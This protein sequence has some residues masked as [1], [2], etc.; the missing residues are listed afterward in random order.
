M[1]NLILF[2]FLFPISVFATN[3]NDDANCMGSWPMEQAAGTS[4]TDLS[5]E[6]ETLTELD[7]N[8]DREA[9]TGSP[10]GTYSRGDF[11]D[12]NH[13]FYHADGGST[14]ISGADQKISFLTWLKSED[15]TETDAIIAKYN[16]ASGQRAYMLSTSTNACSCAISHDGSDVSTSVGATDQVTTNWEHCACTYDDSGTDDILIYADGV[17]DDATPAD[18]GDG[19]NNSDVGFYI[20]CEEVDGNYGEYAWDG[21]VDESAVFNDDL[22]S[23]EINEIIDYGMDGSGAVARRIILISKAGDTVAH[24]GADSGYR[25][26]NFPKPNRILDWWLIPTVYAG[27]IKDDYLER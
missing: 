27:E 20:G 6:G 12:D 22:S 26:R 11:D 1:K 4:E 10:V 15:A 19:I 16:V 25:Q 18:H 14:D 8:I 2:L 23:T 13:Y 5:G 21:L 7:G 24:F 17:S 9:D 3:F